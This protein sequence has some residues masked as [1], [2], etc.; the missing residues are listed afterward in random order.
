MYTF[1]DL[2]SRND[3]MPTTGSCSANFTALTLDTSL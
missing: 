2:L 1:A 3:M